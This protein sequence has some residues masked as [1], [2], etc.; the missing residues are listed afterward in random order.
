[1]G[2][3][4]SRPKQANAE[5]VPREKPTSS[6]NAIPK[7]A[8][9]DPTVKVSTP[10]VAFFVRVLLFANFFFFFFICYWLIAS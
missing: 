7:S 2:S 5:Y 4:A 9:G 3:C 1:M 6:K 8:R 10:H